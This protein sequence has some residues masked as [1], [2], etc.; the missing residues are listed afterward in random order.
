[1]INFNKLLNI[2]DIKHKVITILSFA[3]L[4]VLLSCAQG[5]PGEEIGVAVIDTGTPTVFAISSITRVNPSPSNQTTL[6]YQVQFNKN[7]TSLLTSD[8]AITTTGTA[9]AS[10]ASITGAGS[11]YTVT[12]NAIAGDGTVRL[13]LNDAD[14]SITDDTATPLTVTVFTSGELYT[15]DN[16]PATVSSFT[17]NSSAN[18]LNG[19]SAFTCDLTLNESI[20]ANTL[21]LGDFSVA[22]GSVG[23]PSIDSFAPNTGT[24]SNFTIHLS[25]V[26]NDVQ[27]NFQLEL[28]A[29]SV[30]DTAGNNSPTATAS[31]TAI[32]IDTYEPRVIITSAPAIDISNVGIYTVSGTCSDDGKVVTVSID[33]LNFTPTCTSG[34]FTTGAQNVVILPDNPVL[35]ISVTIA[36]DDAG[37]SATP[38]NTTVVKDTVTQSVTISSAPNID[39]SN[40]TDYTASGTC[41]SNGTTV[42]V[43]IGGLSFTPN[44]SGGTWSTGS[45]DVSSLADSGSISVTADHSTATQASTTISKDTTG[46][47]V[48]ISSAPN[49]NLSNETSYAAS[50]TCTVNG[51]AV[52][53][54]VG[55]LAFSP[56]CSGGTWTTGFQDVSSLADSASISVT[57]DHSAATQASTTITKATATPSAHSLSVPTTL[58]DSIDLTWSLTDPGGF[59]INDY[60][61]NYKVKGAST[62][63]TFNDGVS[64]TTSTTITGLLANTTYETRVRV[65]YDTTNFSEWSNTAEGTTKPDDP[66]FNSPHKAMNV[67]GATSTTVVAMEDTTAITLNGAP[68]VTL[69]KGQTHTFVSAQ[70]D[71]IDADKAIF[72][73]GKVG[74]NGT[75]TQANV[76]WMPTSWAGKSFS[77]NATRHNAQRVDVYAIEDTDITIKQGGTTVA[78]TTITAGNSGSM[79]WSVYGSY[80]VSSTGTILAYHRSTQNNNRYTDP[81][82]LMPAHTEIIG[83]PSSSMR[84]TTDKDGTNYSFIHGNSTANAGNLNKS[85]VVQINPQGTSSLYQGFS[86]LVNADKP[87]AGASFADSNGYCAAPFLPTNLMKTKYMVNVSSDYV[88]FASKQAGTIQVLDSSDTVI[89][90]LTLTRSGANPNAP[91]NVRRATT[92]A[93]YRFISTV[94]VAAWYQPNTNTGAADEDETIL[95]GSD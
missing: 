22:G 66:I 55:G 40:E 39:Q 56:N 32:T 52:N 30:V 16:T 47:V 8:F 69:N 79:T 41:T 77:F 4:F 27:G 51:V 84:L 33:T 13:D 80:Q 87:I 57:A 42:T 70:F 18:I 63:L 5:E 7:V 88:A 54:N 11:T 28:A 59:V 81:K 73:A 95:Y 82:P 60:I 12:V 91:Y 74:T 36:N 61:V 37:N 3:S 9:T 2:Y 6:D 34:A 35:P 26:D 20:D 67:G 15:I 38:V 86:L 78:S 24:A 64:T 89:E 49:I 93:G 29:A 25:G 85:N 10:I 58:T 48:T 31:S 92:P 50:G 68:L 23:T 71:I 76:V 1:V 62:W 17:C 65:Q 43:N 46:D 83:F 19:T 72:T 90:T 14:N 75:N 94:P 45:Q 44:C 21:A 53:V